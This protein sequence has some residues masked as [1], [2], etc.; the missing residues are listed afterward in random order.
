[1]SEI[2]LNLLNRLHLIWEI[3]TTRSGHKHSSS[4]KQLSTF[5]Q[6]YSAGVEDERYNTKEL[7]RQLA[8]VRSNRYIEITAIRTR[9]EVFMSSNWSAQEFR[10]YLKELKEK[11]DGK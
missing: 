8:K 4:S 6:G 10:D 5:Q 2:K 7:K 11:G 9:F 1:M 3:I